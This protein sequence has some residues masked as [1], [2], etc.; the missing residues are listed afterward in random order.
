MADHDYEAG[1]RDGQIEALKDLVS[2]HGDRLSS[3][4]RVVWLL[5]G[6]WGLTEVIPSLPGIIGGG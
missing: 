6:L 1:K 5:V 4:E 3:L 2:K